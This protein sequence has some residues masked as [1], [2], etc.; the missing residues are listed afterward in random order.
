[1]TKQLRTQIE[2]EATPERVWG[3]LTD[4]AAFGEWNPFMTQADGNVQRGE[5]LTIRMQPDGG[6]AMTFRPT[7]LEAEPNERLRWVGR[8]LVRGVFDGEHSFTIE[9]LGAGRV[10][11][12]QQEEFR[13][14]LVPF[15]ARSLDRNTLPAFEKMNH[16]LKRRAEERQSPEDSGAARRD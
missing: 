10:R 15:M 2:I 13:G 9:R 4:F 3:V 7:V 14:I 12:I 1:M 6:R 8:V 11:L 5:R 16:A